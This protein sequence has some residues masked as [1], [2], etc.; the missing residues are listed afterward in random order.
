VFVGEGTEREGDELMAM[1]EVC[2]N[3]MYEGV[4]VTRIRSRWVLEVQVFYIH[5]CISVSFNI[6][7]C[8]AHRRWIVKVV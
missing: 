8:V 2:L 7:A 1:L 6:F 4:L 5:V 3:E